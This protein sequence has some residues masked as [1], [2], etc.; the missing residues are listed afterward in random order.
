MRLPVGA[1]EKVSSLFSLPPLELSLDNG[2]HHSPFSL[3]LKGLAANYL[4]G[5]FSSDHCGASKLLPARRT[6]RLLLCKVLHDP[7]LEALHQR[8]LST[9]F[10][11]EQLSFAG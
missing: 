6:D 9:L 2:A 5:W 7:L 11:E 10:V 4:E 3:L 1:S 8:T